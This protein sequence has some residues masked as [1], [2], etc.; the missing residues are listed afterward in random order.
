MKKIVK[1]H[2]DSTSVIE[3][4][5]CKNDYSVL[6]PKEVIEFCRAKFSVY[7]DMIKEFDAEEVQISLLYNHIEKIRHEI[8]SLDDDNIYDVERGIEL[9]K[10]SN[11]LNS[12]LYSSRV[13]LGEKKREYVKELEQTAA[14]RKISGW[15][16]DEVDRQYVLLKIRDRKQ[17]LKSTFNP[18]TEN[19]VKKAEILLE[20]GKVKDATELFSDLGDCHIRWRLQDE[21]LHEVFNVRWYGPNVHP[22]IWFD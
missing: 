17:S 20:E 21:I 7:S 5:P 8:K 11:L 13:A 18:I 14:Y 4:V 1:E 16:Y 15:L 22:N 3:D 6:P 2:P 19:L 9:K 12:S 10:Q